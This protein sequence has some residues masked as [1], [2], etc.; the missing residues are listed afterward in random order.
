MQI[1]VGQIAELLGGKVQ[2]DYNAIVHGASTIENGKEGS[3]CFLSNLKYEEFVYESEATAILVSEDFVPTQAIKPA[4]IFVSNVYESLAVLLERFNQEP[5]QPIY[6]VA[7]TASID[8]SVRCG[9]N[10]GVGH[11]TVVAKNVSIGSNTNVGAQ[12]F[13]GENCEIGENCLIMPGVRIMHDTIIGKN[14]IIHSNTV[15]GSDG[16]GFAPTP[17]GNY[18]KIRQMGKVIIED[19]VEIGSN[20]SI[21]RATFGATILHQGVKLDNLIQIAHNVEIGKHTVIAAQT[22]VAGSAKIGEGCKI[23]GQVGVVGHI[24]IADGVQIQ[25]QSGIQSSVKAKNTKLFGSP[26]LDYTHFLRSYAVFKKL[27][28]MLDALGDLEKLVYRNQTESES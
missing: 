6:E 18:V 20:C 8:E 21:D 4:L 23:G 26:A 19:D 16:F 28:T 25:G 27:P 10:V 15:I 2:G 5:T 7:T 14:C 24:T 3:L 1:T 12:V 13:I 9:E 17:D 11:Y 22:G